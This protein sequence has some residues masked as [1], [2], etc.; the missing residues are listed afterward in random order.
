MMR[1]NRMMSTRRLRPI[2]FMLC[3]ILSIGF[4]LGVA[5]AHAAPLQAGDLAVI[6][7]NFD[8]SPQ[9]AA[10]VALADIAAGTVIYITDQ[11]W[12]ST[13]STFFGEPI[14]EGT[15]T[16]TVGTAIPRGALYK[17][18]LTPGSP[19]GSVT[20]TPAN[21]GSTLAVTGWTQYVFNQGGDQIFIYQG[22]EASPTFIYGFSNQYASN[23][24]I[25]ATPGQ[26]QL[27]TFEPSV[28]NQS[29]LPDSLTNGTSALALTGAVGN[30]HCENYYYSGTQTA[31][32][33][34]LLA[35]IG[36]T[37][38]WVCNNSTSTPFDLNP[39]GAIFSNPFVLTPSIWLTSL[40]SGE[41]LTAT[42]KYS[43][44]WSY[45][46]NPGHVSIELLKGGSKVSTITPSTAVGANGTG[47]YS[48]TIPSTEASGSGYQIKVSSTTISSFTTTGS[49]FS[50]TGPTV[51]VISPNGS[52]WNAGG[53][54]PIT[55]NYTGNPGPVR[56]DLLKG[57]SKVSTITP[58]T[59]V[60]ANG[61]GSYSWTIPGTEA[62]GSNYQIKVSSTAISSCTT[63]SSAFSIAGPTVNVT[64]P[65]SGET[66]A[67][68]GKYPITWSYTGSPGPVSIDL[69]KSGS[70]V[71]TIIASTAVGANGTG[72]YS[73]TIPGTE[74]S[75]SNYQIKVSSTAISSCTTTS[76]AFSITGPNVS[77]ISPNG[78]SW[79]AGGKYS[80]TW[81]YTGNPG[82]VSIDLL[83]SGSKVST[84]TSSTAVGSIGTGFHSW[85]I[86]NTEASS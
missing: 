57:G 20:I 61:T 60:G 46:G 16:W 41:T 49:A 86:P 33:A 31:T 63:T 38:N 62:S 8:K 67:A 65:T 9:E 29:N 79:N 81:N 83:K 19:Q 80:I 7:I 4:G 73:W 23:P 53:K 55:W 28:S 6:G 32:R 17:L 34:G 75:G 11:G 59:A 45:T 2:Y 85:A 37:G 74:A 12:D 1:L 26:W 77:V 58:S 56:I 70:K 40:T 18:A 64:S 52:S 82:P 50:I 15:I 71:S 39:G 21:A 14:N 24:A 27:N 47:S 68:T 35:S 10:I 3:L 72:S 84:I 22:S 30:L 5:A 66:L 42:G 13:T 78:S 69:L 44:T 43:I 51:S 36:A 76:S 54:Y 25:I 48:W